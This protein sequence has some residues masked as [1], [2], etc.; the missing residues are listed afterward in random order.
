MNH[1]HSFECESEE[2]ERIRRDF[3]HWNINDAF[4][5]IHQDGYLSEALLLAVLKQEL[6]KQQRLNRRFTVVIASLCGT[7][8]LWLAVGVLVFAMSRAPVSVPLWFFAPMILLTAACLLG[9][10][11]AGG[12][13]PTRVQKRCALCLCLMCDRLKDVHSVGPLLDGV[14]FWFG[15]MYRSKWTQSAILALTH[16]LP[17]VT[18][19]DT[20]WLTSQQVGVLGTIAGQLRISNKLLERDDLEHP[21]LKFYTAALVALG[22]VGQASALPTLKKLTCL[23]PASEG[24]EAVREAA[25]EALVVLEARLHV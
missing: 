7:A 4:K 12:P 15:D 8:F 2:V 3:G 25:Q 5:Q 22:Q 18:T 16:L 19:E 13:I 24:R 6:P 23:K 21:L 11:F 17:K 14:G 9:C 20:A 10:S 1:N